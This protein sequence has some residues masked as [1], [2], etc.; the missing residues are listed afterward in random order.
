MNYGLTPMPT[1]NVSY[2]GFLNGD[3]TAVLSGSPFLSTTATSTSPSGTYPITVNLNTLSAANYTFTAV[4]ATFLI[5]PTNPVFTPGSTTFN[6]SQ[7]PVP[8]NITNSSPNVLLYYTLDG[9]APTTGSTPYSGPIQVIANTTIKAIGTTPDGFLTG[10]VTATYNVRSIAPTIGLA[11]GTYT[12]PQSV[13]ITNNTPGATIYYTTDGNPPSTSSTAYNGA[14]TV[15]ANTTIKAIAVGAGDVWS[16]TVSATYSIR[17][18]PPTI[19]PKG[20][21]LYDAANRD[22]YKSGIGRSCLLHDGWEHPDWIFNSV[23]G[24]VPG[25]GQC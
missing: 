15:S 9:S 16:S 1:L 6:Y 21:N 10:V 20:W 25:V 22:Y 3:T 2:V 5:F 19:A 18:A 7:V 23:F 14:I 8:V 4:N 12:G 17:T 11:A 24:F 13:S